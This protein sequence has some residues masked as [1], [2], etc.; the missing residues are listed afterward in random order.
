VQVETLSLDSSTWLNVGSAVSANGTSTYDLPA[1]QY[2]LAV[3][4]G[5]TAIYAALTKIV[6]D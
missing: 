4:L 3:S 5:A 2:R 1:G 6:E